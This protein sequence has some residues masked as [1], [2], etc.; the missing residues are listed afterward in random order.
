MVAGFRIRRYYRVILR[1]IVTL[2]LLIFPTVH[3]HAAKMPG[4]EY[5]YKSWH[6]DDGLP[7]SRVQAITQT[8]DGYLWVGTS[9]GLARF[10]GL[11]FVVFD[12][13]NTPVFVENSVLS[14]FAAKDNSLWIGTEGGGIIQYREKSFRTFSARDGLVN[15]FVRSIYGDQSGRLWVG[16][17]QGVFLKEGDKFRLVESA[18]TMPPVTALQIKEDRSGQLWVSGNG[19]FKLVGKSLVQELVGSS[20]GQFHGMQEH[21]G[22]SVWLATNSGLLIR[23][24]RALNIVDP[25]ISEAFTLL[26][27]HYGD[28]WIGAANGLFQARNGEITS[29]GKQE[30][31]SSRVLA[32]FEDRENNIWAGT[33]DGLVRLSRTLV[34]TLTAQAGLLDSISVIAKDQKD[35]L[36]LVSGEGTLFQFKDGSVHK[37]TVPGLPTDAHIQTIYEDRRHCYW[38]GTSNKGVFRWQCGPL[39]S[40]VPDSEVRAFLEDHSGALWVATA[41]GVIKIQDSGV[42]VFT[43]ADGLIYGSARSLLETRNGDIWI[44]TDSG[45][46]RI[47]DG[48]FVK[49]H[50]TAAIGSERV[51][52][53]HQEKRGDSVWVGTQS[54]GVLRIKDNK[55]SG[56]SIGLG[57]AR[58]IHQIIEDEKGTI[59][60][61]GPRG[62]MKV[63][64]VDL[65]DAFDRKI[66]LTQIIR[67]GIAEGMK[68]VQMSGGTQPAGVISADGDAWFPS[69]KG[70]VFIPSTAIYASQ[71]PLALIENVLVDG[72]PI[73]FQQR[74]EIPPDTHT[75]EIQYTAPNLIAPRRIAL[76]HKLEGFDKKWTNTLR[77]SAFYTALPAGEYKFRVV[78]QNRAL[79]DSQSEA[80]LDLSWQP[81][82]YQRSW[83]LTLVAVLFVAMLWL[84]SRFYV[85]QTKQRY[86]MILAERTRLAREMHDTVIQ[87]CVGVSTLLEAASGFERTNTSLL[88]EML[89]RARRQVR[90]TLEDARQAVWDLRHEPE[91]GQL[92]KTLPAFASQ[93]SDESGVPIEVVI[94]G[95][96]FDLKQEVDRNLLA[97]AREAI[98]NAITHGHPQEVRVVVDY[99]SD[100]IRI[101]VIDDGVGFEAAEARLLAG[102]FGLLGMKERMEQMGGSLRLTSRREH[103]THVIAELPLAVR[104]SQSI[105]K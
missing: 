79:P 61:S 23:T 7:H 56:R 75:L 47:R 10:D 30:L 102:H 93:L 20:P 4:Q 39:K 11:A 48:K 2:V 32:L 70:A 26:T 87:G 80:T 35:Q 19:L 96:A 6:V 71:A 29:R 88:I 60:M 22:G 57:L 8:A 34:T 33:G 97:A 98:R 65:N 13:S 83:F 103:G 94:K 66:P 92:L 27:D 62:V 5:S 73:L 43:T 9:G 89:N 38:I 50:L 58:T 51:W 64:G 105:S 14:L 21:S 54:A 31:P 78:A 53:L 24:G 40:Y 3:V 67:Y 44:G 82:F 55:I 95:E 85:N 86:A 84:G 28:T 72:H 52:A 69:A 46:S 15:Q 17:D 36:W 74:I 81:H 101:E 16:T 104:L 12:R 18:P 63:K 91:A 25:R 68:S 90:I 59:W 37:T 77:R 99:G 100:L 1:T 49:D 42:Q 45:L 76:S 41:S